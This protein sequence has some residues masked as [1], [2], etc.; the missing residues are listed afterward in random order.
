M[1]HLKFVSDNQADLP[2]TRICE[3]IE[4]PRLSFYAWRNCTPSASCDAT[5]IGWASCVWPG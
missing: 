1:I 5:V 3:L 4:V 2:V